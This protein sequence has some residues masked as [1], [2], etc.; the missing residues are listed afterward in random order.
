MSPH[1]STYVQQIFDAVS[2]EDITAFLA[3]V[4]DDIEIIEPASL[5]VGGVHKGHEAVLQKILKVMGRKFKVRILRSTI[6]GEG[7]TFAACA[8]VQFTSRSTG[9]VLEM[10]YV[11]LHTVRGNKVCRMDIYPQ[12]TQR[13]MEFWN[14]N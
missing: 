3:G 9:N 13:L 6:L 10:P 12:D 1:S 2:R 7:P 5:P 4:T 14:A 11:E 8:D